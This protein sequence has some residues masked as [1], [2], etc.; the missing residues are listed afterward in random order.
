MENKYRRVM[1]QNRIIF[2]LIAM[3]VFWGITPQ[4]VSAHKVSENSV[5]QAKQL[6][7]MGIPV[8]QSK[9]KLV[10]QLKGKGFVEKKDA[11]GKPMLSGTYDGRQVKAKV[12]TNT[13]MIE[14]MKHYTLAEGKRRFDALLSKIKERI[15]E[16]TS[17]EALRFIE[18]VTD[19]IDDYESKTKDN[20][21][22]KK[23][24]EDNDA[25]W[26]KKYKDR[27]FNTPCHY[28]LFANGRR[29]SGSI[30]ACWTSIL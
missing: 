21:D 16:D 28:V 7:F 15:G 19:T 17:D 5:N 24:Y 4:I 25:E 20:T 22:W 11:K 6:E 27:F 12:F 13:I 2:L 30:K 1:K 9:N 23:K 10:A 18:D 8:H 14:D 29:S 26:R 3:A